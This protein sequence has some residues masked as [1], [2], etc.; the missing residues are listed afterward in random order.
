MVRQK[1]WDGKYETYMTDHRVQRGADIKTVTGKTSVK[2][3]NYDDKCDRENKPQ[4]K[5]Q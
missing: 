2:R 4:K 5:K 3:K 1:L